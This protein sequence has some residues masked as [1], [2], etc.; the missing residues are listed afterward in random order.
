MTGIITGCLLGTYYDFGCKQRS[1][2]LK[3]WF[4]L[5]PDWTEKCVYIVFFD[6][7]SRACSYEEYKIGRNYNPTKQEYEDTVPILLYAMYPEDDLEL[8]EKVC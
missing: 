4:D 5:Y 1:V 2:Y 3:R 8:L 6:S 7:P